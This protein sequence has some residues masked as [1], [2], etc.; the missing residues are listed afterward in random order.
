ME[1]DQESETNEYKNTYIRRREKTQNIKISGKLT[2]SNAAR[3][4]VAADDVNKIVRKVVND[5]AVIEKE[6]TA[7]EVETVETT[8]KNKPTTA[9]K[10]GNRMLN[11]ALIHTLHICITAE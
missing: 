11:Y 6:V 10:T 8:P 5:V 4:Q 1:N 7:A 3:K 9:G 2:K